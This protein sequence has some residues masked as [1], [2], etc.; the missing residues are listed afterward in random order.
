M[1]QSV[2][3]CRA[4]QNSVI[5]NFILLMIGSMK[6]K[7]TIAFLIF[8]L[9][10]SISQGQVI[11]SINKIEIEKPAWCCWDYKPYKCYERKAKYAELTTSIEEYLKTNCVG[12]EVCEVVLLP[13]NFDDDYTYVLNRAH[14]L[15]IQY[16]CADIEG[17]VAEDV[18]QIKSGIVQFKNV[19]KL[20]CGDDFNV[21]RERREYFN[22]SPSTCVATT[23]IATILTA[24]AAVAAVFYSG[25]M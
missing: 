6:M 5:L 17:A 4:T 14:T 10:C 7:E 8:I 9:I 16:M 2:P 12:K 18:K 1:L 25:S 19:L 20:G 13:N 15:L 23:F 3:L 24:G 21:G 22:C 11:H